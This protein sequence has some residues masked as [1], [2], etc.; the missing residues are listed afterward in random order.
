MGLRV[1]V[2]RS[3]RLRIGPLAPASS[4]SN[5]KG[6][7]C[8]LTGPFFPPHARDAR[9]QP[10]TDFRAV[11]LRIGI[12]LGTKGETRVGLECRRVEKRSSRCTG[13]SV[14]GEV[15]HRPG[16][17]ER[18]KLGGGCGSG[19]AVES[20][21]RRLDPRHLG[22]GVPKRIVCRPPAP[23]IWHFPLRSEMSRQATVYHVMIA[24]PS[25][26]S[27]ERD[28][29]RHA[30]SQWNAAHSENREIVL[31]PIGWE[32]HATPGTGDHPQNILNK[33]ILK[34]SDLLVGLFWTRLGTPT[35][36]YVSGSAE[37]IGRHVDAGKPAMLY[38]S[39]KPAK[40]DDVD[41]EQYNK[42]LQFKEHWRDHALLGEWDNPSDFQDRFY[43]QLERKLNQDPYFPRS[44]SLEENIQKKIGEW[45]S[46][47]DRTFA[48]GLPRHP[49]Y[50]YRLSGDWKSW[51]VFLPGQE[52]GPG[53]EQNLRT[54]VI[55]EQAFKRLRT[56]MERE[57][58]ES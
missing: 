20:S 44:P 15:P 39:K 42:L 52:A 48:G 17:R 56:F 14:V 2:G 27:E 18:E 21:G 32:T 23:H 10:M 40:L 25:D 55:E 28:A 11:S 4:E 8:T 50:V 35:N 49:G 24:S 22:R 30:V 37:E 16:Q 1:Y 34:Q 31:L 54:D 46:F 12:H 53:Y 26:I 6:S 19:Q 29:V 7:G 41:Q 36:D 45:V 38:F 3:L 13:S 33:Q 51:N 9:N 57:M 47:G 5:A 43:F 58:T